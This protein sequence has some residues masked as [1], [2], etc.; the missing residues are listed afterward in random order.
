MC[1]HGMM[2]VQ[3]S[4]NTSMRASQRRLPRERGSTE[5]R[6]HGSSGAAAPSFSG[7]ALEASV[8]GAGSGA[9]LTD[10]RAPHDGYEEAKTQLRVSAQ[11]KEWQRIPELDGTPRT[12][13]AQLPAG[14]D[15]AKR[16]TAHAARQR[17]ATQFR[18]W[19]SRVTS[20]KQRRPP[21]A[22]TRAVFRARRRVAST[23]AHAPWPL[24]RRAAVKAASAG[25]RSS[26]KCPF[27]I[28]CRFAPP[29]ACRSVQRDRE[30][31]CQRGGAGVGAAP[32]ARCDTRLRV[33]SLSRPVPNFGWNAAS[34]Q[35]P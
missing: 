15:I 25:R 13:T 5:R 28:R 11:S 16:C 26:E 34:Q 2:S 30:A 29:T 19:D 27:E 3:Y 8:G 7:S 31:A 1:T 9:T 35:R 20:W 17:G 22:D 4:S 21:A 14:G 18:N 23:S 32:H 10:R 33:A 6:H 24:E 12:V